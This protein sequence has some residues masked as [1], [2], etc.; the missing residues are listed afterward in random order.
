MTATLTCDRNDRPQF[1]ELCKKQLSRFVNEEPRSIYSIIVD[2][3]PSSN[4]FDLIKRFREGIRTAREQ[5]IENIIV[6][7][8]DDYYSH[9]YLKH[10]DFDQYEFIGW[11]NTTYYNI[12]TRQWQKMY[13]EGHSSLCAT[14]IKISALDG[15]VWPPDD[16]L[17]LDI[18][19]WKFAKLRSK[20]W[21]LFDDENPVLGIKHGVGRYGGKGHTLDLREKDPDLS[22]LKSRVDS[23]AFEFYSNLKF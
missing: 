10:F 18:A 22:W 16:N 20:K 21:K 14:G 12:R 3:A 19:L 1:M 6:V 4:Q 23:E 11:S 17:W 7:E 8:S 5:G 9:D 15:F 2:Y 13:H